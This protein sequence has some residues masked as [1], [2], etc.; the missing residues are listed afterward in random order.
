M[1]NERGCLG[2]VMADPKRLDE[3]D[4]LLPEHFP[5]G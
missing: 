2:A 4:M 1:D 5:L 3:L